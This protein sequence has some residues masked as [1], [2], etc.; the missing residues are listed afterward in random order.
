MFNETSMAYQYIGS[1]LFSLIIVT[2]VLLAGG[3]SH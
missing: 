2:K 3:K 1:D